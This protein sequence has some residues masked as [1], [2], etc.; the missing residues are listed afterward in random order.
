MR[1]LPKTVSFGP[2]VDTAVKEPI[3]S[4]LGGKGAEAGICVCVCVFTVYLAFY[5]SAFL[6]IRACL[7]ARF[8]KEKERAWSQI[9]TPC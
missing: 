5:S 8:P 1:G 2:L 7:A 3:G 4:D 9:G 6:G